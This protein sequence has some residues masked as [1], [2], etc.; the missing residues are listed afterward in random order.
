MVALQNMEVNKLFL[1][2][3]AGKLDIHMEK[4]ET[5]ISYHIQK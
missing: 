2:N 4:N 3:N 1:T 5:C